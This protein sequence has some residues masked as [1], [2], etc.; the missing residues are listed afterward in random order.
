[1]MSAPASTAFIRD[2]MVTPVVEWQ[3]TW[4]SLSSPY[5]SLIPRMMSYAGCGLSRAAMS[6]RAMESAPMSS[7]VPAIF[8]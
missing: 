7:R 5:V 3:W 1:M 4:M 2:T 6:L 8:T